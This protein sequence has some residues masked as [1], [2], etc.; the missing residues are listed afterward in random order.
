MPSTIGIPRA[1]LARLSF[2]VAVASLASF[3]LAQVSVEEAD[4]RLKA[5]LATRPSVTQP[6]SD[7]ER[8]RNENL[9][10]RQRIMS[11]EQEVTTLK[12]SLARASKIAPAATTRPGAPA[13]APLHTIVVGRWRGGDIVA[14]SG[15]LIQ[16]EPTGAYKQTFITTG[17]QET[18]Q[19]RVFDDHTLEM[20]NDKWPEDKK[21]NQYRIEASPVQ[22]TLTAT[23][24]DGLEIKTPRPLV[25]LRTE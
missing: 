23:V 24:I 5:K 12:E 21:H 7:I 19:Y 14:G 2:V 13:A 10:L 20:W 25:L 18:G 11:L 17:K 1:K 16:F 8:L 15:Y 22:I 9:R 3:T 6:A 4:R